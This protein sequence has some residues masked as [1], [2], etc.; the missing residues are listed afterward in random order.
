MNPG[1]GEKYI[2]QLAT[3]IPG[4]QL[5]DTHNYLGI[6]SG[7]F[8]GLDDLDISEAPPIG[9]FLQ[10]SFIEGRDRLT[11]SFKPLD[12]RG[13]IWMLEVVSTLPAEKD[14]EIQIFE[15][16]RIPEGMA[17]HILDLDEEC[18]V[19]VVDGRF[20]I[21]LLNQFPIR[22]LK[23][24]IGSTQFAEEQRKSISLVP[25]DFVLYQNYPN[26]FNPKTKISYQ[27]GKRTHVVLEI[28]NI[29]GRKIRTLVDNTQ[30]SGSHTVT[31][32]GL[33]GTDRLVSGGV[34]LY[35]IRT[36]TFTSVKKLIFIR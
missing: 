4:F 1:T 6:V 17:L 36:E 33:D 22:H 8:Q 12:S 2:L 9:D 18:P 14:V 26:P 5:I 31:W 11:S 29:M 30:R 28:F 15:A 23:V 24:I 27:L 7:A 20:R 35:R 13:Q 19:S 21:R 10:L 34:Y 16:G 3:R 32:R 25:L